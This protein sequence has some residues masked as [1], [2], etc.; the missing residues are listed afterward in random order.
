M[1]RRPKIKVY[2][3]TQSRTTIA[4]MVSDYYVKTLESCDRAELL[5]II[6]NERFAYIQATFSDDDLLEELERCQK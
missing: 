5:E 2:L 3:P 6:G 4:T 1:K